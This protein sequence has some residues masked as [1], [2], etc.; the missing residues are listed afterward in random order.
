MT[1]A[2]PREL[3]TDWITSCTEACR[4][5]R[6][7]SK[8][9]GGQTCI[10]RISNYFSF[11]YL[12]ASVCSYFSKKHICHK[13]SQ[14]SKSIC[15]LYCTK[16]FIY[17]SLMERNVCFFCWRTRWISRDA[18]TWYL[19]VENKAHCPWNNQSV[20]GSR[21][22]WGSHAPLHLW[23]LLGRRWD[24]MQGRVMWSH[25]NALGIRL[26][27]KQWKIWRALLKQ[28]IIHL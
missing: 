25:V 1:D 11:I 14:P 12:F 6:C 24:G 4:E 8:Q 27:F 7:I 17:F 23:S 21:L 5:R 15:R 28:K 13:L 26:I 19:C 20:T 3:L 22:S 2:I 10:S 16:C 18:L 9:T